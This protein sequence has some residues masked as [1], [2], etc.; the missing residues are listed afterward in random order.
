MNYSEYRNIH[1]KWRKRGGHIQVLKKG[2]K[3]TKQ[4]VISTISLVLFVSV[5]SFVLYQNTKKNVTLD[6]NGETIKVTTHAKTVEQLLQEQ[7][8]DLTEHDKI[9]PSLNTKIVNGLAITWEQV[10]EVTISVDG[11]QS[12]VWTTKTHV[13]DILKE[14]N[15]E[16][17]EHDFLMQ[18]LDTE[19]G[20]DNQI[21]IQR[22]FQVLLVDGANKRQEWSTSTTVANFLK[23]QG[24]QLNEYDRVEGYNLEDILTPTSKVVVVRVEKVFDVVDDSLD[25]A[26][27]K[28]Q[29]ASLQEGKEKVVN[30]G[31][32]GTISRKYEIVKEN[33]QVVAKNL[34][35]ETVIKEPKNQSVAVGTKTVETS[36]ATSVEPPSSSNEFAATTTEPSNGNEFYVIATAYTAYCNGC[37]GT[38]AT[39]IDLRSYP[40]EKVIAVDPDVIKLGS[41]VWVEGYGTAI[42]GDTGGA[43]K[44][45]KIDIFVPSE[46][47]AINWGVKIVRIKV[48]D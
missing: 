45:N 23:H 26:I 8:I 3:R 40:D 47:Q 15:I 25:F 6:A 31:E 13:K 10:K 22:G 44:G 16:V 36:T 46:T 29:D 24:I 41:K 30:A 7:N 42:A 21:D 38:T 20:A 4:A 14:A 48:F 17:S 5:I 33:G 12:T 27:E 32:K 35:S 28:T 39:G 37:S 43:I 11:N 34:Q 1:G 18:G 2:T 9:S 19:I